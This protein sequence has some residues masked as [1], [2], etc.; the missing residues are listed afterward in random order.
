MN[1]SMPVAQECEARIPF[2][3][4][5]LERTIPERFQRIVSA[6]PGVIALACDA[7]AWTYAEL[8]LRT[9]RL[10]RGILARSAPASD[11]IAFLVDHGPAMIALTLAT[12][13]AGKASLCIHPALP[14][15]VQVDI[16]R[17]ARPGLII[18]DQAHHE[19]AALLGRDAVPVMRVEEADAFVAEPLDS[20]GASGDPAV[21]V[22]TSGSAGRPKGVVKSHRAVLH[23]AWLCAH[24]DDVRPGDRQSLLTSCAFASSEADLFGALLNGAAVE[25]YDLAAQ[26]LAEFGAWID[27]RRITLLHPPVIW[28]RRYLGTLTGCSVHPSV[29]LVALAGESVISSDIALWRRHFGRDCELRHRFSSTEAGHIAVYSVAAEMPSDSVP[30]PEPV[31]DKQL[32]IVGPNGMPVRAGEEGELVVASRFLATGYWR[33]P[34]EPNGFKCD[35]ENGDLRHFHTGDLARMTSDGKL[36]FLG[37]RDR[38]VKIRGYRV[39]L[40]EIEQELGALPEV[41]EAAVVA[42]QQDDETHL[43][44]FLVARG[45]PSPDPII[46][47]ARLRARLPEWKVPGRI[48]WID[49]LPL[50]AN[51]K[52]DRQSLAPRLAIDQSVTRARTSVVSSDTQR[53][54]TSIWEELLARGA[55]ALDD[56]FFDL[57]GHSLL[58]V[59]LLERIRREFGRSLSLATLLEQPTIRGV[60]AALAQDAPPVEPASLV[61]LKSGTIGQ[62]MICLPAADGSVLTYLRLAQLLAGGYPLD[63]VQL[64]DDRPEKIPDFEA[65]AAQCVA[66]IRRD[67]PNG[68]YHLCGYCFGGALA[69]EAARQLT[70]AGE[71]VGLVAMIDTFTPNVPLRSL[72]LYRSLPRY[73]GQLSRAGLRAALG[74]LVHRLRHSRQRSLRAALS[75]EGARRAAFQGYRPQHYPGELML[76]D[77]GIPAAHR[78]LFD[79]PAAGWQPFCDRIGSYSIACD[80]NA[81]LG[82]A[83]LSEIAAIL[84]GRMKEQA[85]P[86]QRRKK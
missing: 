21:I 8:D 17:D 1:V 69:F 41:A 6:C 63:A 7:Q 84:D 14:A 29:R 58:A 38:Q 36:D 80:H 9:N 27:A 83:K 68:P 3:R 2:E 54:M 44:A 73:L 61:R 34:D 48:A 32:F 33:L 70:V 4:D 22:Y 59:Q 16:L 5:E 49:S 20:R 71:C 47:R 55:I 19:T 31:E 72:P 39:E 15:A 62:P 60:T 43:A 65:I 78:R 26:G 37:R 18:V 10:A 28:F 52:V 35:E 23:R 25:V 40:D 45:E 74:D 42:A 11:C 46:L 85:A 66:A 53:R 13:K 24:Y 51:G 79:G 81:L 57:G 75:A 76:L 12:L 86:D 82:D 67:R 50:T 30:L 77:A 64:N 56:G